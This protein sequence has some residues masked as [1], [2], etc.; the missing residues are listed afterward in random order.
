MFK[1]EIKQI[2]N[3]QSK[4]QLLFMTLEK[5]IEAFERESPRNFLSLTI[6]SKINLT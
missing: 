3:T 5:K 2:N 4:P 1:M 6:L